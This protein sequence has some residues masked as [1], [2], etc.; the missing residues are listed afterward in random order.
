M[1]ALS[2]VWRFL[3][4]PRAG[5]FPRPERRDDADAT[6]S[7]DQRGIA[8]LVVLLAITV[9]T[10]VVVQFS[11]DAHVDYGLAQNEA[12]EVRAYY[13]ARSGI[14]F[15][16]LI[17]D[18]DQKL[19]SNPQLSQF[20]QSQGIPAISLWKLVPEID[21]AILRSVS[22]PDI[23]DDQKEEISKQF[24][25]VA[26]DTLTKSDGFLDFEG[27][28]HVE[29]ADEESKLNLNKIADERIN[30]PLDSSVGRA[31]YA[32]SAD[33]KFDPIFDG[34][35]AYG[36]RK[37][38]REDVIAN[39]IDWVDPNQQGIKSGGAE[40]SLYAEYDPQYKAKNGPFDSLAEVQMV[41]GIDDDWM[42]AFGDK[43]TVFSDGKVNVNTCSQEMLAALLLAGSDVALQP[44]VAMEEAGK[45][46]K[47]R[48]LAPFAQPQN[49]VDFVKQNFSITL[50]PA[51]GVNPF[52]NRIDVQSKVFTLRSTGYAGNA[53][54]TIT[55]V[56]DNTGTSLRW[57]YWRVN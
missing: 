44:E 31:L 2:A 1:K 23:P 8:L 57:L 32:M 41:R 30:G 17:L 46:V 40:D 19:G 37:V 16:K 15:Y 50:Q 21:T 5:L 6:A 3:N 34:Q 22:S 18:A 42:Q 7:R 12:D 52:V 14:N 29:I 33:A 53:R 28:L 36:E 13:L 45:I 9:I 4:E 39:I 55:A 48:E 25:G 27:D 20:L 51:T 26:F 24:G 35:N 54:V 49:F 10:A 11:L 38:P 56:V 47:F 43:I